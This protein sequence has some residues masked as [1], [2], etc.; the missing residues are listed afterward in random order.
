MAITKDKKRELVAQ[1]KDLASSSQG[2][3]LTS[4][5]GLSVKETEDLRRQIREVGGQFHVVKNTLAQLAFEQAGLE[6]P[7]GALDGTTAIGFA[8]ENVA[9]LA[10]AIMDVVRG[11]EVMHIKGGLIDGL[12]YDAKQVLRLANLPP[13]PIL[14]AQLLGLLQ[15]PARRMAGALNGSVQQVVTVIS[16][17]AKTGNEDAAT[18]AV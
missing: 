2:M 5:S 8:Q 10:K 14:Q 15:T 17:F 16:A 4:F 13:L 11:S 12:V 3:I 1:Y 6:L 7:E 18:N 9:D